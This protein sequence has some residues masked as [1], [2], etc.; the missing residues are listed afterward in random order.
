MYLW[1]WIALCAVQRAALCFKSVR[2]QATTYNTSLIHNITQVLNTILLNQDKNFRPLNADPKTPLQVEVDISVRSMG[3]I[4]EHQM[5]FSLDC[6]FRQ[7]WLDRRLAFSPFGSREHLPLASKMLKDI[8][9]PDTL[10][11]KTKCKM[12]FKKFPMDSQACPIEIGSLAFYSKD[13]IYIWKDVELDSKMG[14]M[15]SQYQLLDV[16]KT[17]ANISDPRFTN[18]SMSILKVY[19]KL[20]RQQG[21]YILQI[22]TPCT[23]IVVM[24]WVSFWINKEASPARVALGIMTVLSMST[25]GF[26]SRSD[27]PKVSH[28]TALDIYI[29]SCFGFVF[30]ALVEYAIINYAYIWYIR[31][32]VHDLK[33]LDTTNAVSLMETKHTF[34]IFHCVYFR[35]I[36]H[37]R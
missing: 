22:Y 36:S 37:S 14:N 25:L 3:P 31:K 8:W 11:I 5:E 19:F 21:F 18:L 28:S 29:I 24:S 6:Y 16:I 32:K 34:M 15:L 2:N 20:Q 4:S 12:F 26:G 35:N 17:S 13:V 10:T 27:L 7:K 30:A 33:G 1:S 9:T 23:L